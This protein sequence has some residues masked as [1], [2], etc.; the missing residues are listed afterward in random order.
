MK[1]VFLT[2]FHQPLKAYVLLEFEKFVQGSS[3]IFEKFKFDIAFKNKWKA[4][5][6]AIKIPTFVGILDAFSIDY[7]KTL[8]SLSSEDNFRDS[9]QKTIS[10]T[11]VAVNMYPFRSPCFFNSANEKNQFLYPLIPNYLTLTIQLI[12]IHF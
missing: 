7:K 2:A 6:E 9:L 8:K 3:N 5:L 4:L 10:G 1:N 12:F 11:P